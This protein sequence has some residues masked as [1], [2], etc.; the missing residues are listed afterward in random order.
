MTRGQLANQERYIQWPNAMKS[1]TSTHVPPI[2]HTDLGT[3][4]TYGYD[5]RWVGE[6]GIGRFAR[7]IQLRCS[8]LAPLS[9]KGSPSSP[10]D[11][12]KS[13]AWLLMHPH[14]RLFSPG[15]NAPL[16]GASR[17]IFVLHDLNHIERPES[18]SFLKSLYYNSVIKRGCRRAMRVLTVSE[19]SRQRILA[20][21][22]VPPERIVNVGNGVSE[23]FTSHEEKNEKGIVKALFES[24]LFQRPSSRSS[25]SPTDP[26]E[27]Q[28]D[29]DHGVRPPKGQCK[30]LAPMDIDGFVSLLNEDSEL[31]TYFL[32]VSNR[33][34]HKNE[35]GLLTAFAKADL[36][37]TVKLV[38]TGHL[39][40]E[41]DMALNELGLQGRV[42]FAGKVNDVM[43]A[44]LYR[45]ARAL[46]FPSFYE[47]FG[48]PVVESMACGTP[49]MTSTTT[50]LPEIAGGAAMLVD[51]KD[52]N[53]IAHAI[54]R[55]NNDDNLCRTLSR[56]G[57]ERA[58]D[59]SW[60]AVATRVESALLQCLN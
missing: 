17:S 28:G 18:R 4:N 9:L 34:P 31:F 36:P 24:A 25:L 22:G 33:R 7:E 50:S 39:T 15:Y 27:R 21:S 54:I 41:L 58:K 56:K 29:Q 43:L 32:C 60:A 2:A 13:A 42:L 47:G 52:I 1:D 16:F 40:P 10:L 53:A 8:G 38:F 5:A 12:I 23:V 3:K 6:H 26:P 51:P 11:P 30:D 48:L 37:P 46:L 44:M 14:R 49:V 57:L 59:F 55:L 45:Q 35:K 19:Y 20:W